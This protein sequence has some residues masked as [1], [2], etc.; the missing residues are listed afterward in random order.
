MRRVTRPDDSDAAQLR[1]MSHLQRRRAQIRRVFGAPVSQHAESLWQRQHRHAEVSLDDR[2]AR[3]RVEASGPEQRYRVGLTAHHHARR[4][5][6]C[7]MLHEAQK[8]EL[9]ANALFAH[10]Q[11]RPTVQRLA[12]PVARGAP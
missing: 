12:A 10:H 11:N 5:A 9:I 8:L 7:G 6:D 1:L 2:V 4:G 3:D